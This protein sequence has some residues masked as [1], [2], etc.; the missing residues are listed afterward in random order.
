MVGV[1]AAV[2]FATLTIFFSVAAQA[3]PSPSADTGQAKAIDDCLNAKKVWVFVITDDEKVLANQC[4]DSPST[5]ADV[6]EKAGIT[7]SKNKSGLICTMND[8][9]ATCPRTFNGQ[10]WAYY[11][12]SGAGA[13][14]DYSKKGADQYKPAAG[15]IEGW[16]YNK[17]KTKS[18]T[19]PKLAAGSAAGVSYQLTSNSAKTGQN[20]DTSS[21]RST[22][23]P[24][25]TAIVIALVVIAL[26]VAF[27]VR[28]RQ[29]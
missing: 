20:A 9:P 19:P 18:C 26:I 27:V 28:R 12:A 23:G 15:S 21:G 22:S 10:Y 11:H 17:P 13:A 7:V 29:S 14:W 16:C 8:H 25:A 2:L 3:T 5:G 1:L 4:V 6:L 24:I